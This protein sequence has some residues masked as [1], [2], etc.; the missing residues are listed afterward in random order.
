MKSSGTDLLIGTA[1]FGRS[2]TG[3]GW[4]W[5]SP[6]SARWTDRISSGTAS[7]GTALRLT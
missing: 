7:T 6:S 5:P 2:S 3:D 1:G 4:A